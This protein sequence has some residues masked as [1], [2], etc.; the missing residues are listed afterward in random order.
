MG[1]LGD[2]ADFFGLGGG[3]GGS[4]V[5]YGVTST[6][7]GGSSPVGVVSTVQGGAT[8]IGLVSTIQ[9]G[10]KDVGVDFGLDDVNI[11]IGGTAT[12]LHSITD[13]NVPLPIKSEIDFAVTEPIN[14][15]SAIRSK[16]DIEPVQVDLCVDVGLTKLPRA[17][18]TQPY[19]SHFGVTLWGAEVVGFNWNG[20]SNIVIDDLE[21]RTHVEPGGKPSRHEPRRTTYRGRASI[22]REDGGQLHIRLD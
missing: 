17:H 2:V 22:D 20:V 18:I 13:I 11:D 8:P 16:L 4:S 7:Q 3:S 21:K 15:D 9:G 19:D 10:S 12:P 1:I 6:I 14:T 5:N